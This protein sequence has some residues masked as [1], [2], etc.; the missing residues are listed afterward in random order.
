MQGGFG[1]R[2]RRLRFSAQ[3]MNDPGM[4]GCKDEAEG[5]RHGVRLGHCL[6]DACHGVVLIAERD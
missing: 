6:A 5:M 1:S 3:V 4:M 2:I